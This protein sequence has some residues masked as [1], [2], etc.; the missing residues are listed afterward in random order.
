MGE[1]K[2]YDLDQAPETDLRI[3]LL[4]ERGY[5]LAALF[6]ENPII[7]KDVRLHDLIRLKFFYSRSYQAEEF[8]KIRTTEFNPGNDSVES[9]YQEWFKKLGGYLKDNNFFSKPIK[10]EEV[11]LITYLSKEL[12][13]SKEGE[14]VQDVLNVFPLKDPRRAAIFDFECLLSADYRTYLSLLVSGYI[15]EPLLPG[16]EFG[17]GLIQFAEKICEMEP[18]EELEA[19]VKI[20]FSRAIPLATRLSGVYH[21]LRALSNKSQDF[22]DP[23]YREGLK[24]ANFDGNIFAD[25]GF[26]EHIFTSPGQWTKDDHLNFGWL[27]YNRTGLQ[28]SPLLERAIKAAF[29]EVEDAKELIKPSGMREEIEGIRDRTT[30]TIGHP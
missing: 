30:N 18:N 8:E 19:Y 16:I 17:M 26:S 22:S 1:S 13:R 9:A 6:L 12:P 2:R 21:E 20:V 24:A 11:P 23:G 15:Y 27:D 25:L 4:K 10:A 3:E 7:Y 5:E 29:K 28:L 14:E